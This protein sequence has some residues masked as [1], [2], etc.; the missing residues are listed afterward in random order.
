SAFKISSLA[1]AA[2]N[3][4]SEI[5]TYGCA[6]GAALWREFSPLNITLRVFRRAV[7]QSGRTVR[8][9]RRCSEST[10][11][12]AACVRSLHHVAHAVRAQCARSIVLSVRGA[13]VVSA[14]C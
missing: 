7:A 12:Y 14:R 2:S 10:H 1:Q 6:E 5:S 3:P 4:R 13:A 8:L 9:R 11:V